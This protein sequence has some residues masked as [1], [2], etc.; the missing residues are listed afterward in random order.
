MFNYSYSIKKVFKRVKI[1][2]KIVQI[3]IITISSLDWKKKQILSRK[4][5][6]TKSA[7]DYFYGHYDSQAIITSL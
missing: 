4:A 6:M 5:W 3:K 7:C 1:K 2:V